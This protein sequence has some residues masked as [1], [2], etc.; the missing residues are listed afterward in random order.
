MLNALPLPEAPNSDGK[1]EVLDVHFDLNRLEIVVGLFSA[2]GDRRI[3]FE[4][5]KGFRVLDE[6]DL[7]AWWE[8]VSSIDGWL[9]E[10]TAGGWFAQE[11]QRSD[12][13]SG[14]A[15][16]YREFL[17]VGVD[18]CVCVIA[19]GHPHVSTINRT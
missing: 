12:F 16:F 15:Q 10:V 3:V 17:V 13:L 7:S 2:Q 14:A 19:K 4:E 8:R 6:S 11:S 18:F 1:A 5:V 9:F